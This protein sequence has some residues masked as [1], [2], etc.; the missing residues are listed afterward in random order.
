MQGTNANGAEDDSSKVQKGTL[1][2]LVKE[3]M[4]AH[5]LADI[6]MTGHSITVRQP[7]GTGGTHGF[8]IKV[9][10]DWFF[11]LKDKESQTH[12]PG[13]ACRPMIGEEH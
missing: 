1:Y 4:K 6:S 12:V 13:N 2:V 8:D 5:S 11:V 9:E 7:G 3:L 10:Q